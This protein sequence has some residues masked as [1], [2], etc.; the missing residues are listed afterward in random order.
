MY[1]C[2]RLFKGIEVRLV[3]ET[4]AGIRRLMEKATWMGLGFPGYE[5]LSVIATVR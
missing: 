4:V 2:R 3:R 5:D 1:Y